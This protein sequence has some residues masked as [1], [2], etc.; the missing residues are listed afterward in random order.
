VNHKPCS[1][2]E[3]DAIP[4]RHHHRNGENRPHGDHARVREWRR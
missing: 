2:A 1:W 3:A 4:E